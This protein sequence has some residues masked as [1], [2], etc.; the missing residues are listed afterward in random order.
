MPHRGGLRQLPDPRRRKAPD[1][2]H[3]GGLHPAG[4]DGGPVHSGPGRPDRPQLHGPG[5]DLRFSGPA[6]RLPVR[7]AENVGEGAIRRGRAGL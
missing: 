1:P 7:R 4:P 2:G 3:P 5:G 6:Q